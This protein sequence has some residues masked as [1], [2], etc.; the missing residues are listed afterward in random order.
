MELVFSLAIGAIFVIA[1]IFGARIG[2]QQRAQWFA[3]ADSLGLECSGGGSFSVPS[4][5]GTYRGH[6]VEIGKVVYGS[7]KHRQVY[8]R[9]SASLPSGAPGGLGVSSEGAFSAVGK[10]F[11]AQDIQVGDAT[12]DKAFVIKGDRGEEDRIGELMRHGPLLEPLQTLCTARG[13]LTQGLA[14]REARSI[15]TRL[16]A[17]ERMLLQ[18]CEVADRVAEGLGAEAVSEPGL[19]LGSPAFVDKHSVEVPATA[20]DPSEE[21]SQPPLSGATDPL[22]QLADRMLLRRE[23]EAILASLADPRVLS[24]EVQGVEECRDGSGKNLIGKVGEVLVEVKYPSDQV[25]EIEEFTAGD[26]IGLKVR[27]TGWEDF[28][29]RATFELA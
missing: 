26:R 29:R 7:G 19:L 16:D 1:I 9:V 2:K 13:G 12:I 24:L 17:F 4:M 11:G 8:T 25:V 10:F 15:V 21:S 23:R 27:C 6:W 20:D 28:A 3:A 22:Q 14:W 18:V 5:S